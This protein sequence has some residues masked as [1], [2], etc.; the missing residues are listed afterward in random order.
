VD[1]LLSIRLGILLHVEAQVLKRPIS[2]VI[3]A[4]RETR[5]T[6]KRSLSALNLALSQDYDLDVVIVENGSDELEDIQ[7][8]RHYQIEESGLGI[9]LKLGIQK[10]R[11]QDTFFLPADMSY[12]LSFV[13][14]ALQE[15]A[16]IVIGSKKVEGSV[17]HRPFTSKAVS[18]VYAEYLRRMKGI[19]LLDI[20]GVKLY[21]RSRVLPLLTET[22]SPGIAFEVELMQLA[23]ARGLTIKEI[24]VIVH[25]R[26]RGGVLRW[27]R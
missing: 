11:W 2:I 1:G 10:A 18:W 9:A 27:V 14:F 5:K 16:D 13:D 21:R 6:L 19:R 12:D 17:V 24:P 25:D 26:D 22:T 8:T 15:Q 20:T 3:P 7:G 4:H 23:Q